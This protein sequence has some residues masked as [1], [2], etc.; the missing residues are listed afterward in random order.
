[1]PAGDELTT[2]A[3]ETR[4][5]VIER[6]IGSLELADDDVAPTIDWAEAQRRQRAIDARAGRD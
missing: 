4:G 3:S 1:M 6:A 5:P 2:L